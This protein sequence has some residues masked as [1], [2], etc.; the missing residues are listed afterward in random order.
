LRAARL[1]VS[2]A[3]DEAAAARLALERIEADEGDGDLAPAENG[4]L[5]R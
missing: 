1:E 2:D 4:I 5:Q 3:E